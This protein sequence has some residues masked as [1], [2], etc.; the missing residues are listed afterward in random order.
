M[1]KV[2]IVNCG[3]IVVCII[4]ACCE[5]GLKTVAIYSIVD[6]D[7]FYA[8]LADESICIGPGLSPK[9]YLKIPAVMSA[10]EV[11]GV[12][13]IHPGYGFLLENAEFAK[14]CVVYKIKWI[15]LWKLCWF[16]GM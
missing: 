11:V 5:L 7:S 13:A 2:L 4:C 12:D 9:S 3:E 16:V 15:G 14:I 8:K 6:C 10:V 1:K